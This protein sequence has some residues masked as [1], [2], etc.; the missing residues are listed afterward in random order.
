MRLDKYLA[1]C[2][3]GTRSEIKKMIRAGRVCV[4]GREKLRPEIQI[5]E[6]AD[7]VFADGKKLSYKKFIYLMLNKP[8]GYLSATWDKRSPVVLDL[9]PEEYLHYEPFPVGR[10]DIDTEGLCI[11]TNDGQLAHRLLSPVNH[12]PKMYYAE[13]E[14]FV[15]AADC[16]AFSEGILLEDGYQTKP[17]H[18]K[19]IEDGAVSKVQVTITEGKFHQIKR[20]F[21]CVGKTV[22]YLKRIKMN[23]LCL[24]ENLKPGGIRELTLEELEMLINGECH[25]AGGGNS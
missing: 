13:V 20:M 1:D 17:G 6:N 25:S 11:L 23:G 7:V 22:L 5:D 9:V 19:V 24:D 4:T 12:I 8:A 14:G 21:A 3:I 10:L 16:R 15:N 18:L 2:G